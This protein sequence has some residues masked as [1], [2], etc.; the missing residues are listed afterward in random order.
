V[1][2]STPFRRPW[3]AFLRHGSAEAGGHGLP[4]SKRRLTERG[5]REAE[6]TAVLARRARYVP[7]AVYTSPYP[8]ARETAEIFLDR[9]SLVVS[10][11]EDARIEPEAD[12]GVALAWVR[13]L[14]DEVASEMLAAK[15]PGPGSGTPGAGGI[16]GGLPL[17]LFVA[18]EPI[19]SGLISS[20]LGRRRPP[21]ERA[22]L[23]VLSQDGSRSWQERTYR[24]T[25]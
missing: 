9:L 19:L 25:L 14:V 2:D 7:V 12:V 5:R 1:S 24:P 16:A 21:L 13:G 17:L 22:E 3:L 4:D 15:A 6:E 18:H 23:V 10:L 8:R 20:L 11:R